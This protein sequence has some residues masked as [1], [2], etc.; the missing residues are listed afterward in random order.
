MPRRACLEWRSL[1][2]GISC[3]SPLG[4]SRRRS[5][6]GRHWRS[7][8]SVAEA[9]GSW[10]RTPTPS[11]VAAPDLPPSCGGSRMTLYPHNPGVHVRL[12]TSW[13]SSL[14]RWAQ[15]EGTVSRNADQLSGQNWCS[16][17]KPPKSTQRRPAVPVGCSTRQGRRVL[18]EDRWSCWLWCCWSRSDR[19][20][21]RRTR[22]ALC[23]HWCRGRGRAA[24]SGETSCGSGG[25]T[26]LRPS[27]PRCLCGISLWFHARFELIW[28]KASPARCASLEE[29]LM[30]PTSSVQRLAKAYIQHRCQDWIATPRKY[31]NTACSKANSWTIRTVLLSIA[32]LMQWLSTI[33]HQQSHWVTSCKVTNFTVLNK[34][35]PI[36]SQFMDSKIDRTFFRAML[37]AP[38]IP[39]LIFVDSIAACLSVKLKQLYFV[40]G[41]NSGPVY[42]FK[43]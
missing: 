31:H 34:G 3:R 19:R 25:W 29:Q 9:A 24:P 18:R 43:Q 2:I 28:H 20:P 10:S 11:P 13:S 26:W 27:A 40:S 32:P 7:R 12:S 41:F 21:W 33:N 30:W 14:D 16:L 36:N 23:R 37:A 17:S 39:N 8:R 38:R 5:S 4:S 1:C 22:N 6:C 42:H 15:F 35:W